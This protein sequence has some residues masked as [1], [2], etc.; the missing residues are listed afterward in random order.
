MGEVN[1]SSLEVWTQNMNDQHLPV[2]AMLSFI[3]RSG[4]SL[5]ALNLEAIPPHSVDLSSLLQALPSIESLQLFFKWGFK[6]TTV[7]DDILTRIFCSAPGG[8]DILVDAMLESFL[9]RLR[10]IECL[11]GSPAAPFSWDHIPKLY[12]QGHRRSLALRSAAFPSHISDET[13]VQLL[14][15]VDEGVGLEIHDRQR[16]GDFL[17]NFRYKMHQEA[18]IYT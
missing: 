10:F 12:R 9:P 4:C 14:Q 13:G 3:D 15:L 11:T 18:I 2:A 8:S 7:M 17:M 16:G 6:D 1:L 5:K